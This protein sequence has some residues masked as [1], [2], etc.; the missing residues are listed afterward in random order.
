MRYDG[1]MRR[2]AFLVALLCGVAVTAP[3]LVAQN[4][5]R[6]VAIGDIHGSITGFKSILK[7]TGLADERQMD[8]R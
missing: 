3:P 5:A 1:R 6:I 4:A 2:I 8:R 7:V